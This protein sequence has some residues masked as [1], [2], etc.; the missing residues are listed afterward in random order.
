MTGNPSL[1]VL[2]PLHQLWKDRADSLKP[3]FPGTPTRPAA[4]WL[5]TKKPV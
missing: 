4:F 1:E 2:L 3:F 5:R